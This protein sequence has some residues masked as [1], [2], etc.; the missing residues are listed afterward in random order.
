MESDP[1]ISPRIKPANGTQQPPRSTRKRPHRE[2]SSEPSIAELVKPMDPLSQPLDTPGHLDGKD[3]TSSYHNRTATWLDG[4]PVQS[5]GEYPDD[6]TLPSNQGA[7]DRRK[8]QR[9]EAIQSS[10]PATS[11]EFAGQLPSIGEGFPHDSMAVE[12]GVGWRTIRMDDPTMR[13]ASTRASVRYIEKY[14]GLNDVIIV[15]EHP[16]ELKLAETSSG[17]WIFGDETK[18]GALLA[19]SWME[20]IKEIRSRQGFIWQGLQLHYPAVRNASNGLVPSATEEHPNK[21]MMP[22]E[23][24]TRQTEDVRLYSSP[25][26]DP[27]ASGSSNPG[28][29]TSDNLFP[30]IRG[31]SLL[32]E[33]ASA[34]ASDG[35][36]MEVDPDNQMG[37][38]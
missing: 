14:Y 17:I 15:A 25:P 31:P 13:G 37:M 4:I 34:G 30:T 28:H 6:V 27:E 35:G 36:R 23:G 1:A 5:A 21:N 7:E 22:M 12:L 11:D 20:C 29:W 16:N 24:R 9:Q 19:Y 38:S 33:E 18:C 2:S 8:F 3:M 32:E 26:G 10:D